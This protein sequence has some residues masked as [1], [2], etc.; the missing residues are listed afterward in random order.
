MRWVIPVLVMAVAVSGW[1]FS[2]FQTQQVS[3]LEKKLALAQEDLAQLGKL[4]AT[5]EMYG[6][7]QQAIANFEA[8]TKQL[9]ARRTEL[10]L[11]NVNL[12]DARAELEEL[13]GKSK[14]IEK[15]LAQAPERYITIAGAKVRAGSS[16]GT[17]ELAVVRRGV[18]VSVFAGG[19]DPAWYKV[20]L[21]GFMYH[22]LLKPAP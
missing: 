11:L 21:T 10:A 14:E 6:N 5:E 7:H 19:D 1:G 20:S 3:D 4:Q 18:P 12:A 13:W 16:T 8:A 9:H 17:T 22:E 2:Y 15:L